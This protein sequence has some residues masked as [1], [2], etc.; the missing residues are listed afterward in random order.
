[1]YHQCKDIPVSMRQSKQLQITRHGLQRD[2]V[3]QVKH[4]TFSP[5]TR[6]YIPCERHRSFP[7]SCLI[8]KSNLYLVRLDETCREHDKDGLG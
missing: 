2:K 8:N 5:E 6:A 4:M 7:K 1:M 3:T